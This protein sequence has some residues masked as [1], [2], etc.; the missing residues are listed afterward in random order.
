MWKILAT[1]VWIIMVSLGSFAAYVS[2]WF[3]PEEIVE[4]VD[5][6]LISTETISVPLVGE[7]GVDGYILGE[8]VFSA[9]DRALAKETDPVVT[10][11]SDSLIGFLQSNGRTLLSPDFELPGFKRQLVARMN[12]DIRSDAFYEVYISRLDFVSKDDMERQR[13]RSRNWLRPIKIVPD[14]KLDRPPQKP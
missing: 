5:H 4:P 1:G 14:D 2:G 11:M 12:D 13:D 9:S 3:A 7:S 8:F 6:H 10:R